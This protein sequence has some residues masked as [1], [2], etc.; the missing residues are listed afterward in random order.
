[1]LNILLAAGA[2]LAQMGT[3]DPAASLMIFGASALFVGIVIGFCT[4]PY[5]KKIGFGCDWSP[6]SPIVASMLMGLNSALCCGIIGYIVMQQIAATEMKKYGL[7]TGF[8][9][10]RKKHVAAVVAQLRANAQP[11]PPP[12]S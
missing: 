7:K 12:N 9:G 1:M 5:N 10:I 2:R 6:A 4:Y 3:T 8:G 11:V